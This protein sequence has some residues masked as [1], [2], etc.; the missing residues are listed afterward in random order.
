MTTQYISFDCLKSALF[1]VTHKNECIGKFAAL[2]ESNPEKENA[3]I[4]LHWH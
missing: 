4:F 1:S 3:C 2:S